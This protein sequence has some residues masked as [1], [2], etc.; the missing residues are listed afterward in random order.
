MYVSTEKALLLFYVVP[1]EITFFRL[2]HDEEFGIW[3]S[4][5][6]PPFSNQNSMRINHSHKNRYSTLT[7][8]YTVSF[9]FIRYANEMCRCC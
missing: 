9:A 3:D 7:Q 2:I 6:P 8:Q 5:I 1:K 4:A